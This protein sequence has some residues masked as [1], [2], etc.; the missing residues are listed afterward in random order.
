MNAK[1]NTPENTFPISMIPWVTFTGFQQ[2][3]QKRLRLLITYFY[4][5]KIL[6]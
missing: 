2:N 6:R 3:L 4:Y 5:W 1:P